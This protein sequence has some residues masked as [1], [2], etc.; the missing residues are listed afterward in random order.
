MAVF[1]LAPFT[2]LNGLAEIRTLA[3]KQDCSQVLVHV[4]DKQP[5]SVLPCLLLGSFLSLPTS[6][7]TGQGQEGVGIA[8]N[9]FSESLETS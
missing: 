1:C 5:T 2:S 9:S 4:R 8:N 6:E 3:V 7:S